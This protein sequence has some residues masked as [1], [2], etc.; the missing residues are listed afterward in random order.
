MPPWSCYLCNAF[1]VIAL[2]DVDPYFI[3]E[4]VLS[5]LISSAMDTR[6]APLT[7]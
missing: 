4:L 3:A 1:V 6:N 2:H 7:L 5:N